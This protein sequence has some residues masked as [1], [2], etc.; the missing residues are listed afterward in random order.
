MPTR[1]RRSWSTFHDAGGTLVDTAASYGYGET[2]ALLGQLL[3]DVVPR[4]DLM[5]ATKAGITRTPRGPRRRLLAR[6]AAAP[7]GRVAAQ[8]RHRLRR[9]LVRALPSTTRVPFE[10]TLGALDAAVTQ[11]QGPLR[12][13]LELLRLADRPGRHLAA[14]RAR[15]R[16]DRGQPGAV[17]AARPRHRARGRAGLPRSSASACFPWS[18]LGGGV[19]TG[20]YRGGVPADSRASR[21]H[22]PDLVADGPPA[23]GR[24]RRGGGHRGR[25]AGH[26][27][28]RGGAGLAA[29]P[30]RRGRARCSGA[31]T[32]GQLTAALACETLDLP[33]R[34]QRRARRRVG[35]ADRATRRTCTLSD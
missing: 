16:A 11:R 5:I 23:H 28:G 6:R 21:G 1:R 31:R 3:A 27:A 29:R 22:R 10:E 35:A 13:G 9:P 26:L 18:P 34:D 4:A 32:L 12:R 7:A 19:L 24:H 17:L 15:P 20:K 30:A 2:E 14:G 8:A 33:R 25:R